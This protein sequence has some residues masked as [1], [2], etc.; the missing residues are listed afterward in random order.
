MIELLVVTLG[1]LG[2][3]SLLKGR[4]IDTT[5]Y[6]EG[7]AYDRPSYEV[8]GYHD[9]GHIRQSRRRAREKDWRA[10]ESRWHRCT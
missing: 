9:D 8:P 7:P 3:L 6:K 4:H 5:V 2:L 10:E 1:F